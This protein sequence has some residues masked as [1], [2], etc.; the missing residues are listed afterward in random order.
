M[1]SKCSFELWFQKFETLIRHFWIVWLKYYVWNDHL[2]ISMV[3]PLNWL[4][5]KTDQILFL[6]F[7]LGKVCIQTDQFTH[8]EWKTVLIWRVV[9]FV[10]I[11]E[12]FFRIGCSRMLD[13]SFNSVCRWV[14]QLFPCRY[15]FKLNSEQMLC[16]SKKYRLWCWLP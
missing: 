12:Q 2:H 3:I 10:D 8:F 13:C 1:T 6:P 11:F 4:K 5:H 16:Q 7:Q 15:P 14:L 9:I